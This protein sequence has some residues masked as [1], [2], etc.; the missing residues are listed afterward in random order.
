MNPARVL[1]AIWLTVKFPPNLQQV[2]SFAYSKDEKGKGDVRAGLSI[3]GLLSVVLTRDVG[4]FV[5]RSATRCRSVDSSRSVAREIDTAAT[6]GRV[7]SAGGIEESSDGRRGDRGVGSTAESAS[8]Q[9]FA[10][11]V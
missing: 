4:E 9:T 8:G 6:D 7:E 1:G 10:D 2:V 11:G 3:K 5:G